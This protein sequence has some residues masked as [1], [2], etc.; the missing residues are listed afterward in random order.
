MAGGHQPGRGR[1]GRVV[2][3][4]LRIRPRPGA[5]ATRPGFL[6]NRNAVLHG[7]MYGHGFATLFL[8]EV[9]GMV[10]DR[11]LREQLRDT[12]DRAVQLHPQHPERRG[13]LALPAAAARRRHVGDHLPDHGPARGPQRR[14]RRARSTVRQVHRATSR[15]ARTVRATAAS[16]TCSG[17]GPAG[18]ARTAAGVVALY[19]AGIYK[20]ETVEK[21]LDYLH[22]QL[23]AGQP[24]ARQL[25]P[26]SASIQM[27]YFYGHY[28][29]V[30]AMWTAGGR[31][32]PNGIPAIRDELVNHRRPP[33]HDGSLERSPHLHPLRHRDG[34]ASSCRSRTTTCR[35]SSD[36][37][38][39]LVGTRR[40]TETTDT[41]ELT[42]ASDPS[43]SVSHS[44]SSSFSSRAAGEMTSRNSSFDLYRR[45]PRRPA[46]WSIWRRTGRCRSAQNPRYAYPGRI[47]LLETGVAL[48][49]PHPRTE[50]IFSPTATA[51]C[52]IRKARADE[53][54]FPDAG[55]RGPRTG[56]RP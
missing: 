48:L 49:P 13:R 19:S 21:G 23:P 14:H 24:N 46:R 3:R 1:Y 53:R 5:A 36:E 42:S 18:F 9:H 44:V 40:N 55:S 8:A 51:W 56:R 6:H 34:A 30:Q 35:S 7:P 33:A 17:G 43:L 15:T 10:H 29:A 2:T 31:Y 45:P 28:Y 52:S 20:G 4:A 25:P 41:T 37:R 32:W 22:A 38:N 26:T 12:L 54:G 39:N 11:D 50:Q 47:G 16:A 27:H